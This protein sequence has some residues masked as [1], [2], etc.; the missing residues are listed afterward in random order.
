MVFSLQVME[1]DCKLKGLLM[2]RVV[3]MKDAFPYSS[4]V[5]RND[6]A[7]LLVLEEPTKSKLTFQL[8]LGPFDSLL[9]S[10]YNAGPSLLVQIKVT[11]LEEQSSGLR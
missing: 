3:E 2:T 10:Q 8:K 1:N 5:I 11:S 7:I 9:T 4:T 6:P